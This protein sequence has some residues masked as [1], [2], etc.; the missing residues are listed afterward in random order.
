MGRSVLLLVV[1]TTVSRVMRRTSN[2]PGSVSI[3]LFLR[4]DMLMNRVPI[5]SS[6]VLNDTSWEAYVV[7]AWVDR[8]SVCRLS[9]TP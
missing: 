2:P 3:A 8:F 1:V 9:I 7:R 6:T 5:D 4:L